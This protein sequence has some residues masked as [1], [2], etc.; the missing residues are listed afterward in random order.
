ML[1][2]IEEEI[3]LLMKITNKLAKCPEKRTNFD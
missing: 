3:A 2:K 1:I